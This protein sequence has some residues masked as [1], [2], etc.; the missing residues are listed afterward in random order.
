MKTITWNEY[1]TQKAAFYAKHGEG[2]ESSELGADGSIY[3][4]VGFKDG[5]VWY[6]LGED[7]TEKDIVMR[8]GI[9][10]EA[11]FHFRR[12]EV[13]DTENSA[14]RYLYQRA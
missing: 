1:N 4:T 7:I 8:H 3:K 6:E 9:W 14:S 13:W 12:Y 5:A 11:T 2:K 10:T